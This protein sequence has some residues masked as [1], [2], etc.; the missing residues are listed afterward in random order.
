MLDLRDELAIA[1]SFVVALWLAAQAPHLAESERRALCAVADAA[2][3]KLEACLA[4]IDRMIDESK[5]R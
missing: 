1:S 2:R 5:A 4:A 3:D